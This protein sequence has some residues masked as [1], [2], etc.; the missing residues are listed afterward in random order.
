MNDKE[1]KEVC[2]TED[3]ACYLEKK[4]EEKEKRV[5]KRKVSTSAAR[6]LIKFEARRLPSP[7]LSLSFSFYVS[8]S[9]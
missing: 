9:V 1:E 5:I 8:F 3:N 6:F 7:R 4:A 2:R